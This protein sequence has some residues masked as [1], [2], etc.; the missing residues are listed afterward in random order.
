MGF[1]VSIFWSSVICCLGL[2]E[3]FWC[4]CFFYG[5]YFLSL[6]LS[7]FLSIVENVNGDIIVRF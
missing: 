1:D 3:W 6:V 2:F 4:I 5:W 7:C